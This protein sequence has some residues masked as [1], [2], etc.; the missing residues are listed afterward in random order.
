MSNDQVIERLQ[1]KIE[2]II[3]Q[4]D[5]ELIELSTKHYN[6]VNQLTIIA[7]KKTGGITIEE[8]TR[9]HKNIIKTI[10]DEQLPVED[11]NVTVSSPGLDRPL[12]TQKDF[13]RVIGQKV[14]FF[15]S[16]PINKKIEHTGSVNQVLNNNVVI[17]S[18]SKNLTI[19]ITNINKAVQTI[20]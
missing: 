3:E 11:F 9:I 4:L 15:L 17:N 8:C 7:D 19:P 20:S 10:E 12:K 2:W 5:C 18:D 13:L 16:E 6:N 14:H 1:P